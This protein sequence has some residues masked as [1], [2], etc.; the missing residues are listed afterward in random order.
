M[1]LPP[2]GGPKPDRQAIDSVNPI[3]SI[4]PD[5]RK[6][7]GR[8]LSVL[9]NLATGVLDVQCGRDRVAKIA[10]RHSGLMRSLPCSR[11]LMS[12]R[13]KGLNTKLLRSK[14][15]LVPLWRRIPSSDLLD[16]SYGVE[17]AYR[18]RGNHAKPRRDRQR[19]GRPQPV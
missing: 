13:R 9:R 8:L 7:T 4:A 2:V 5:A 15:P 18:L 3:Q 1:V 6:A 19:S 12:L 17:H 14:Q 11:C 16:Q 10:Q